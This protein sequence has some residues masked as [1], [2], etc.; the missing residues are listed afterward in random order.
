MLKFKSEVIKKNGQQ[1]PGSQQRPSSEMIEGIITKDA[2]ILEQELSN[3]LRDL[4]D[5]GAEN[6][7]QIMQTL[8]KSFDEVIKR[9]KNF[10]RLLTKIK[11]A[12][13]EYLTHLA[14]Q[15]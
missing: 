11:K 7:Q 1:D 6:S 4:R 9:D 15:S 5:N 14:A 10:G 13:D 12:Y 2:I 8:G 3:E